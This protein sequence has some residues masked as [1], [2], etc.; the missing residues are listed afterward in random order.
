MNGPAPRFI[1][2]RRPR[3]FTLVELLVVIAIISTLIALLLPAVQAARETSRR[4]ACQSNLHNF[5]MAAQNYLTVERKF[6]V[7]AR[8]REGTTWTKNTPPPL[9]RHNGLSFMLPYFENGATFNAIDYDW[10]WNDTKHSKNETYTKHNIGGILICPTTGGG[11]DHHHVSD[12]APIDRVDIQNGPPHVDDAPG[13]R[14]EELIASG[15]IDDKKG[16]PDKARVWDGMMQVDYIKMKGD[17][18]EVSDRRRVV[19]AS[20]KDGLSKTMMYL[21][22]TGKPDLIILGQVSTSGLANNE[23]RWA[24]QETVSHLQFYCNGTQLVN[25]SNRFRAY[26]DH[27]GG[28]NVAFGDGSVR[29]LNEDIAPQTFVSLLTKSGKETI[30]ADEY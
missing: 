17:Q 15:L 23:Y 12:Y 20:V 14:I 24:S 3:G 26:S 18:I 2:R 11:R 9:S 28:I 21:E 10:D 7:A 5:A 27:P 8:D 4:S 22:S 30:S 13:G 6:P 16:A 19:P 29:F 25:C 1:P